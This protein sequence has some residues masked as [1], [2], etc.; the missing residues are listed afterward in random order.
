M[1]LPEEEKVE[2]KRWVPVTMLCVASVLAAGFFVY[3][4]LSLLHPH[5]FL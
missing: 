4:V 2:L 3:T 5:L 1:T